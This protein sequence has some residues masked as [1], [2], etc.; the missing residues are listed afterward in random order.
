MIITCH[1]IPTFP[2]DILLTFAIIPVKSV[3]NIYIFDFL[4][5]F[6]MFSDFLARLFN[7]SLCTHFAPNNIACMFHHTLLIHGQIFNIDFKKIL[8]LVEHIHHR[9]NVSDLQGS[10]RWE[11]PRLGTPVSVRTEPW[12]VWI[13][14]LS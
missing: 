1:E 8:S 7:Y 5:M 13:K 3:L 10:Q 2:I 14:G 6:L 12:A 9:Y 4:V 11:K